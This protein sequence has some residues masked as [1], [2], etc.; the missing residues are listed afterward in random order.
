M[1]WFKILTTL[2]LLGTTACAESQSLNSAASSASST[3]SQASPTLVVQRVP[4]PAVVG[5]KLSNAK[6]VFRARGLR[7]RV[8]LQVSDNSKP[9]TVLKTFP[10][11]RSL[12]DPGTRVVLVVAKAPP[13]PCLASTGN[14][15]CYDFSPG[16]LIY[17]PPITFCS[18]FNCIGSFWDGRGYVIQCQDGEFS[19]SGGIQGSCSYHGGNY[20]PLYAH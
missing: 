4:V 9:R 19:Q 11:A 2:L 6:A 17:S 20:R 18:F 14:P 7:V 3:L 5:S 15:W 16:S 1:P 10:R 12:V 13:N 8:R